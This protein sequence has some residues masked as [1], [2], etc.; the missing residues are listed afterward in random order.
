MI[1]CFAAF[2]LDEERRELRLRGREVVLEPQVF[3][4][5][6]YLVRNRDHVVTKD[7]LLDK[8]WEGAV[9]TEGSIQRAVSLASAALRAGDAADAMSTDPKRGYRFSADV[10]E[11]ADEPPVSEPAAGILGARRA[12]ERDEWAAALSI[13][14][15]ADRAS[16]L[17]G[18]DLERAAWCLLNLGRPA[19]A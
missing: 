9:V 10:S 15:V 3:D 14:E 11:S 16:G 8:L 1:W 4:A 13:F 12:F 7:E 5:L 2:E 6:A 17:A 18:P 19:D